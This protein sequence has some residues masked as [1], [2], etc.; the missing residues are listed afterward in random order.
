MLLGVVVA[1]LI[2]AT[3]GQRAPVQ[4][5]D[6]VEIPFS[7]QTHVE[8]VGAQCL[9]CHTQALRAPQ[10]GLPSLQT[11]MTCHA[12]ITVDEEAQDRVQQVV[13]AYESGA[14]VQ[15]PDVY[16]QPDFVYFS[17]RPHVTQGVACETCHGEVGKMT[18]VE[19]QVEMDMG[20]CLDC[21]RERIRSQPEM[22]AVEKAR[23]LDCATCHK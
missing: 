4:A 8:E 12:Y 16:K 20:F 21:H 7:H 5:A 13:D 23:L 18:I 11:C 2:G 1:A 19:K 6:T 3:T 22:S 15:W 10:A 14:R 9:F 17:H